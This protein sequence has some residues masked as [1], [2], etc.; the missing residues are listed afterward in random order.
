[1]PEMSKNKGQAK[2]SPCPSRLGVRRGA[3]DTIPENFAISENPEP[4]EEDH[5]E[6]RGHAIAKAV[7][8]WLP[9]AAN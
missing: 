7:S 6:G 8:R 5:G 1:M 2:C 9:N 3:N 4:T